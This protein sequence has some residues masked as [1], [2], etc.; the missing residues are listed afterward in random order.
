MRHGTLSRTKGVGLRAYQTS[1]RDNQWLARACDGGLLGIDRARG[2]R[3]AE[4][5]RRREARV[6]AAVAAVAAVAACA[7]AST[8]CSGSRPTDCIDVC[9]GRTHGGRAVV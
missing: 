4:G 3:V 8:A 5:G 2:E 7:G 6:F 9:G 1:A